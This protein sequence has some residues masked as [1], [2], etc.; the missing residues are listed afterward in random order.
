[1]IKGYLIFHLNLAF[2]SIE[3]DARKKVIENCYYPLL[4]LIEKSKTPIG[5][6]LTGWTLKQINNIDPKWVL[7]FKKLIKQN[8]CELI[9][10]GYSQMIGPLIPYEVNYWNQKL[11]L[12]TYNELLQ[13]KPK[14]VLVNEMAFS[15][16]MI[17]LYK[18]F[19]YEGFIMDRDNIK[20]SINN[21][22]VPNNV[23]GNNG[24]SMPVLWSD[25]I[26]FQKVQHYAHGD[27]SIDDYLEYI[28]KRIKKGEKVI[29]IYCNDAE[30]F[31]YRPGRFTEERPTHSDGEWKRIHKL[32]ISLK[33]N[34]NIKFTLPSDA[35]EIAKS[36]K[37][38][39][40][41][42]VC[43]AYPIPVKKQSKYNI[44]RWAVTGR[45]DIWLNTICYRFAKYFESNKDIGVEDWKTLCEFWASD[46]RT[47]ITKKRWDKNLKKLQKFAD[48]KDI[49]TA[50]KDHQILNESYKSLESLTGIPDNFRIKIYNE[51]TLI[52]IRTTKLELDLN[53]RRGLAI[54]SLSFRSHDMKSCIGTLSHGYF[55]SISYGADFYS[56]NSIIEMPLE[57]TRV[58]D[59]EKVT[60][61]FLVHP[62]GS[63]EIFAEINTF[64]GII[65]KSIIVDGKKEKIKLSYDLSRFKE[66][67]GSA[68]LGIVTLMNDFANGDTEIRFANG[69]TDFET[70][71]MESNFDHSKPASSLVSSSRGLGATTGEIQLTANK[72]NVFLLWNPYQCAAFPMIKNVTSDSKT[73]SRLIFSIQEYDDTVKE[74]NKLATNF[75]FVIST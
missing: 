61:K 37:E 38:K 46:L 5:I 31:D 59:L 55:E 24:D 29:P 72:K 33:E 48:E 4:N 11:G 56:G 23:L 8:K 44:A 1:M 18:I 40:K 66:V 32:L 35:I 54:K 65:A 69:G 49:N 16:S 39:P 20:I 17:N 41:K 74:S 10:S 51:N 7:R 50:F 60:P 57:R 34:T 75:S 25:S 36:C 68:R 43:S 71:K 52:N 28:N 19:D 67:F 14:L 30:V 42:I 26:L 53:L 6:E 70:F 3:Q 58:T 13:V 21:N 22:N 15:S 64:H 27:I 62:D 12:L 73:L 2:S 47:H 45:N 63:L 9:G